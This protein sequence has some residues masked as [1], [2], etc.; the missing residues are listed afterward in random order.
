MFNSK[1]R[2]GYRYMELQNTH[3]YSFLIKDQSFGEKA[4]R[5]LHIKICCDPT[6]VVSSGEITLTFYPL[7]NKH[8]KKYDKKISKHSEI[9]GMIKKFI[10]K[11]IKI[12]RSYLSAKYE[13]N[14]QVTIGYKDFIRFAYSRG[15]YGDM[16]CYYDIGCL[17]DLIY[18][19]IK[20]L[21]NR[22]K[23]K[24]PNKAITLSFVPYKMIMRDHD[25]TMRISFDYNRAK[26]TKKD[27]ERIRSEKYKYKK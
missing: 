1:I 19:I 27:F 9:Y 15:R 7:D 23:V 26:G 11:K 5:F 4:I 21:L 24:K 25:D 13:N 16:S 22:H 17:Q 20:N 14:S 2:L 8:V 3:N 12:I 18:I 10:G 6:N